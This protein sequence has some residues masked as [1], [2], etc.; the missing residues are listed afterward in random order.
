MFFKIPQII[1]LFLQKNTFQLLERNTYQWDSAIRMEIKLRAKREIR[2]ESSTTS[3]NL[4][5]GPV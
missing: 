3:A 2:Q 1:L 5:L 4:Q